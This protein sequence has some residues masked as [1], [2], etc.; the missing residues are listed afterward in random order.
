MTAMHIKYTISEE[1]GIVRDY[2]D[3]RG[4]KPQQSLACWRYS[5]SKKPTCN[6]TLGAPDKYQEKKPYK[7]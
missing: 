6:I 1:G 4:G 3:G 5:K 7:I 2:Y